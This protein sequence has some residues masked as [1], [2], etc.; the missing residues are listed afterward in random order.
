[1]EN[2]LSRVNDTVLLLYLVKLSILLGACLQ[3]VWQNCLLSGTFCV[4]RNTEVH[5]DLDIFCF[6]KTSLLVT[7]KCLKSE[8]FIKAD[9]EQLRYEYSIIN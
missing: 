5:M 6:H 8:S 2:N 7:N 1:M 4:S 3:F 9:V